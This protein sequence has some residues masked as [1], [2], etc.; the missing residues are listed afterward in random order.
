MSSLSRSELKILSLSALGGVLEFYDFI[1]FVYFATSIGALFFP[2]NM[3]DWLRQLQTF[4]IFA[5][6]YLVRPIGGIVMAHFGDTRGRKK[7]FTLSIFLM[8]IPTL[9]IGLMPTYADIGI[10]APLILLLFR[11][12]QGAAIGGEVPGAWVFVAEHVAP[13][14]VSF[15]CAVLTAGLTGGILL[16]AVVAVLINTFYS[17][18]QILSGGWR[19]PFILGG[20][21]G[22]IAVFL[23]QWLHETPVFQAMQQQLSRQELPLKVVLRAHRPAIVLTALMTWMLSAAI[24]TMILMT[25]TLLQTLFKVPAR[26]ALEANIFATLSLTAGCLVFGALAGKFNAGRVMLIGSTGLAATSIL[27][28]QQLAI[29]SEHIFL[30]YGLNGFFVGVIA[31]IPAVGVMAFPAPVRFSGLSFSYNVAYAIFGGLTPIFISLLIPL[32]MM[33]PAYYVAALGALGFCIGLYLIRK[34]PALEMMH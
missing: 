1:I 31:I 19:V 27:F 5:A 20:V 32:N 10:L 22:V 3:P 9:A 28:Y 33:S 11:M 4:G 21:F 26:L 7:M 23:R 12:M 6:G 16:G 24:V 17:P 30:L 25:P 15:A 14:Y 13:R 18:E 29:S 34:K 8:A 2:A